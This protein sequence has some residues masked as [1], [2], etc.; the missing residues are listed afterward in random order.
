MTPPGGGGSGGGGGIVGGDLVDDGGEIFYPQVIVYGPDGR[1]YASP[2]EAIEAGVTNYS[3]VKPLLNNSGAGP[4]LIAGADSLVN[5]PNAS[6][7]NVNNG[8]LIAGQNS[9]LFTRPTGIRLPNGVPNP[10]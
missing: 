1:A 9:Q 7:G 4:G 3:Y 6:T 8:A 10:F 2:R 5:I